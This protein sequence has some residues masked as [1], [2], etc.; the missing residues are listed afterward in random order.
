MVAVAY[1]DGNVELRINHTASERRLKSG[2]GQIS[3]VAFSPGGTLLAIA[4]MPVELWN[5]ETDT[6]QILEGHTSGVVAVAF[7]T[8]SELASG[9]AN[10]IINIWNTETYVCE[11]TLISGS[12]ICSVVFSGDGMT[13]ASILGGHGQDEN[14]QGIKAWHI[15]PKVSSEPVQVTDLCAVA[16]ALSQDGTQVAAALDDFTVRLWNLTT[17]S[18]QRIFTFN[19][20]VVAFVGGD[21]RLAAA[22]CTGGKLKLEV[23][24]LNEV[25]DT[26]TGHGDCVT[27][28]I[29]S[30]DG[31]TLA[32]ASEDG[33]VKLWDTDSCCLKLTL[34]LR[35]DDGHVLVGEL[36]TL[37]VDGTMLAAAVFL[38]GIWMWNIATDN[39]AYVLHFQSLQT[40]FL[41]FSPDS[42]KLAAL[43]NDRDGTV[44]LLCDSNAN[45]RRTLKTR[46]S[47][48]ATSAAFSADSRT[49]ASA[50]S[51]GVCLW[52]VGSGDCFHKISSTTEIGR[53]LHFSADM[54][55]LITDRGT[56]SIK[57]IPEGSLIPSSASPPTLNL[58]AD[59]K[60]VVYGPKA[61]LWLPPQYRPNPAY[62]PVAVHNNL[63]ALGHRSGQVTIIEFDLEAVD[64]VEE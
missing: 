16:V 61:L 29:I 33:T 64:K 55:Y 13:L 15:E 48:T 23:A 37:S 22:S 26:S 58:A 62:H 50:S 44:L 28:L 56:L 1:F 30:S 47:G 14:R 41:V 59:I 5:L 21:S 34:E 42:T 54:S 36:M 46:Q 4:S 43:G 32:S 10:G 25:L 8:R 2:W 45:N 57:S 35:N 49:L 18:Y 27:S 60:W 17:K 52:S 11:R 51:L 12:R 7:L 40:I 9:G 39:P 3:S 6:K 53:R 19:A 63:V 38:Q 24:E 20:E 31:T